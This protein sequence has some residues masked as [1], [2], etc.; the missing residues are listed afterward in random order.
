MKR[1]K[2][3]CVFAPDDHSY[4]AEVH[5]PLNQLVL[6]A[7]LLLFF[8]A[9]S[10]KLGSALLVPEYLRYVFSMMGVAGKFLPAIVILVVLF[11]QHLMHLGRGKHKHH[12]SFTAII[13]MVVE[14]AI[15]ILPLIAA[16]WMTGK[17]PVPA[18]I[19]EQS[20]PML[21]GVLES[22]GAGVYEEFLFRMVFISIAL[23]I[24][25]DAMKRK[26][27]R[28][29]VGAIVVSGI[30][31]ALCHLSGAQLHGAA[32]IRWGSVVFLALAGMWWGVLFA[33]R[34]FGVAVCSHICWDLLVVFFNGH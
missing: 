25:T 1:E 34:G 30:L 21:R 3:Q 7:G 18:Q 17:I 20:H 9:F 15:S 16:N 31:F 33:W 32:A 11:A 12:I 23:L 2:D 5:R 8:H 27:N 10:A 13:G 4:G 22:V 24:F 14:G 26:E 29:V 6:V 19:R 28:V